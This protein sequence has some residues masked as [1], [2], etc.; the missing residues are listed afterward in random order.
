MRVRTISSLF[1]LALVGCAPAAPAP[2]A[3]KPPPPAAK[4]TPPAPA[5]RATWSFPS[6]VGVANAQLD[7]GDKGVLQVGERGR[8]WLFAKGGGEPTQAATLAPQ[9]L[10]D[11]RVKG[12]KIV[13]LG[14][15]GE[16]FTVA[17]PL[18]AIES[19]KPA[20]K[21]GRAVAFRAGKD[22]L[23][24]LQKDGTLLRSTDG[25]A[26]WSTSKV[27]LR[28]GDVAVGLAANERG[29]ALALLHPQRLLL[30]SDDG[31]TW[32]PLATPG[33]GATDVFRDAKGDL[34]LRGS[35]ERVARLSG[36]K[37]E[38]AA[39]PAS[40]LEVPGK[41]TGKKT[42]HESRHLA[43]DRV[44]TLVETFEP[45]PSK[46]QKLE[47]AIAAFGKAP[48]TPAS[49]IEKSVSRRDTRVVVAG[50]QGTVVVAVHDEQVDPPVTKFVRSADDGKTWEQ[51]GTLPGRL[52]SDFSVWAGPSQIIVGAACDDESKTCKPAQAKF[53]TKDWQEIPL[54]PKSRLDAV[55]IDPAHDRA[56]ILAWSS[57]GQALLTGSL[58]KG[59]FTKTP[60]ELPRSILHA[61]SV[62]ANGALRLAYGLPSRVVRVAPDLTVQPSWYLPFEARAIDLAGERGFAWDGDDAWETADGGEKWAKVAPG[63][64]GDIECAPSGCMQSGVVRTGWDLPDPKAALVASTAKPVTKKEASPPPPPPSAAPAAAPIA[65]A[66]TAGGAWKPL[67]RARRSRSTATCA[68]RCARPARIRRCRWWWRA[69]RAHRTRSRCSAREARSSRA[70]ACGSGRRSPPRASSPSATP[71]DSKNPKS[72]APPP[73]RSTRRSTSRS[74]GTPARR[75]RRRRRSSRR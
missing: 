17:D 63:T 65:V 6:A 44:V 7:L 62:D 49:V 70:S 1:V 61:T 18:G 37:L 38:A 41:A 11:A 9:D 47:V 46:N 32:K 36:D 29:E 35:E 21:E 20:P 64:S 71:S 59:T 15:E 53:G 75:A 60:V 57:D 14:E 48:A 66:C 40:F 54:P 16:V 27:P 25:G 67:S 33:I 45:P 42:S 51:V 56:W 73:T 58:S 28:P 22:A 50:Y 8:R 39:T 4:V 23:L 5:P 31:A 72:R 13:L 26:T 34:F 10:V 2:E 24:G 52:G 69:A 68:S 55:E 43:G 3:P 12:A 30:S 74:G 19:T